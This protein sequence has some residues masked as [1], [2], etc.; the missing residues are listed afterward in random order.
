MDFI[1]IFSILASFLFSFQAISSFIFLIK[2][3]KIRSFK[4]NPLPI[5]I[6]IPFFN[7]KEENLIGTINCIYEQQYPNFEIIVINDGSSS[8]VNIDFSKYKN[9]KYLSYEVN[10]GKRYATMM[11]IE[12]SIHDWIV[13]VDS[14]TVLNKNALLELQKSAQFYKSDAVGGTIALKNKDQNLLT[15][16]VDGMYWFS[17]FM[18]RSCQSLFKCVTC[19][20]G[21]LSMYKKQLILDNKEN[22]VNQKVGSIHCKAGDD[23]HLTNVFIF[24]RSKVAWSP[25]AVAQT[26]SPA[27]LLKFLRQQVRWSRSFF[28]E[29]L[30]L[31][32]NG[33]MTKMPFMFYVLT[34]KNVF[35]YA[36]LVFFYLFLALFL[37]FFYD[38]VI[39]LIAI[40]HTCMIVL[41]KGMI[42]IAVSNKFSISI[43][44]FLLSIMG[45]ILLGPVLIYAACSFWK[46]GWMTRKK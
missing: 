26:E 42:G 9:L 18:D 25:Y 33:K 35:R 22:F 5:S 17:F 46:T 7:E 2:N 3:R 19:C 38:P 11:G 41:F 36:Y 37:L 23:R 1:I 10:M 6:I 16:I 20:S 40:L 27:R 24:N 21:A 45:Y 13:V 32:L 34:F 14:D 43:K 30:W 8:P 39:L 28:M 12:A 44:V 31:I 4:C 29:N 15:F